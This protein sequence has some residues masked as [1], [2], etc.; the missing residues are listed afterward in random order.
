MAQ[1]PARLLAQAD[2]AYSSIGSGLFATTGRWFGVG[3][4]DDKYEDAAELYV[5]AAVAYRVQNKGRESGLAYEKVLSSFPFLVF[6]CHP[7]PPLPPNHTL[8]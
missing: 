6:S 4:S 5:K 3:P 8:L 7:P 1:D 2:K